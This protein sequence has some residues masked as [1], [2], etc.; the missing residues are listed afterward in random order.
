MSVDNLYDNDSEIKISVLHKVLMG[1]IALVVIAGLLYISGIYQY[2]FYKRTPLSVKQPTIEN[3]VDADLIA[4]PL[5]IFIIRGNEPYGSTRDNDNVL[6]LVENASRIWEQAGLTLVIKNI[7]SI[8]KSDEEL[9]V[10]YN[11]PILFIKNINHIDEVAINALLVG[12][13]GGI[14]GIAFGGL[15]SIA[16]AD[17]TTVYDFRAFA[18]E[19][20]HIL[21]LSHVSG[22]T[23]QLMYQG[24]NGFKLSLEEIE[25]AR[26]R[27]QEF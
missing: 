11:T 25:H 4:I 9:K 26:L 23:N 21:G 22:S 24:A 19:V 6:N 15:R 5:N 27:A 13:L 16:V 12:T 1:I 17:Y 3:R 14:N 18:H 2:F 8:S 7:Y 20:G 10:L